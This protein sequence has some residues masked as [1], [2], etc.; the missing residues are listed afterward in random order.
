VEETFTK[1]WESVELDRSRQKEFWDGRAVHFNKIFKQNETAQEA[2][3]VLNYL[4]QKG[5]LTKQSAILDIG[6]GAGKYGIEFA[7]SAKE[8]ACSDISSEMIKYAKQNAD[9]AGVKNINFYQLSWP[10]ADIAAL[11]WQKKFDLVFSAYCPGING[12]QALKKMLEAGRK[13]FFVSGFVK[14]TDKIL[15]NLRKHFGVKEKEWG[16][17][18]YYAFNLLW[19]WGYY[20]EILYKDKYWSDTFTIEQFAD[21]FIARKNEKDNINKEEV[22]E[23]LKEFSEDGVIHEETKSKAIWIYWKI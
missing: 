14:R 5:A 21:H 2:K 9:T 22:I 20:P 17:R 16:D 4:E 23:Y 3:E 12:A 10:D 8:V 19:I 13:H 18:L 7:K 11:G 6:C 15:G 1:L